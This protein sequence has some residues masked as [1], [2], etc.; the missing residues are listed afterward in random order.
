MMAE[1]SKLCEECNAIESNKKYELERL[2]EQFD[3]DMLSQL[4]QNKRVQETSI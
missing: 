4:Q 2:V 1:I 3:R